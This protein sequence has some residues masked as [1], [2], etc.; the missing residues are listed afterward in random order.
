MTFRGVLTSFQRS[1]E[2]SKKAQNGNHL[3]SV[4]YSLQSSKVKVKHLENELQLAHEKK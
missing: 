2:A 4:Y 3:K 1:V